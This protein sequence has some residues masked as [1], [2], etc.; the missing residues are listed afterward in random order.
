MAS[1]LERRKQYQRMLLLAIYESFSR[2]IFHLVIENKKLTFKR[3][4]E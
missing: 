4:F 1:N 3:V 2:D